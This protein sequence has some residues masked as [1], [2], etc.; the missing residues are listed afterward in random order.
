LQKYNK[1]LP[2]EIKIISRNNKKESSKLPCGNFS[3][4]FIVASLML[5]AIYAGTRAEK[6]IHTKP[7]NLIFIE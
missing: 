1:R 2:S 6:N 7:F 3:G 5:L 4:S